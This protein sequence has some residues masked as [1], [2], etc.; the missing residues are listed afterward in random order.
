VLAGSNTDRSMLRGHEW[1]FLSALVAKIWLATS[2]NIPSA[3]FEASNCMH[4]DST[5]I[6]H[7]I[8]R[9]FAVFLDSTNTWLR[10]HTAVRPTHCNTPHIHIFNCLNNTG[11]HCTNLLGHARSSS[12]AAVGGSGQAGTIDRCS[13][14]A[15]IHRT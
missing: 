13:C 5:A 1:P 12:Q 9:H 8:T 6:F 2:Y 10:N 11:I 14:K 7:S 3:L 4:Y 15:V